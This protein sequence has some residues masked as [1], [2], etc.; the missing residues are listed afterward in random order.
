ML[1][2]TRKQY[3]AYEL[4]AHTN[5]TTLS[6]DDAI[7]LNETLLEM[8]T[9]QLLISGWSLE[10]HT[11]DELYTWMLELDSL[12][13]YFIEIVLPAREVQLQKE[14][15]ARMKA[16]TLKR[17][18]SV[19]DWINSLPLNKGREIKLASF[20]KMFRWDGEMKVSTPKNAED[21]VLT[22]SREADGSVRIMFNSFIGVKEEKDINYASCPKGFKSGQIAVIRPWI[23][24]K[25]MIDYIV[26]HVEIGAPY[27]M[28]S[29]YFSPWATLLYFSAHG[30]M[31]NWLIKGLS[32]TKDV[33]PAKLMLDYKTMQAHESIR[34]WFVSSAM[35]AGTP[36][37][38]AGGLSTA[39]S[40][41][42]KDGTLYSTQN[43]SKLAARF[44]SIEENNK[45]VSLGRKKI[46]VMLDVPEGLEDWFAPGAIWAPSME[47]MKYGVTRVTSKHLGVKGVTSPMMDLISMPAHHECYLA[48]KGCCKYGARG[49]Y[50]A[51]MTGNPIGRNLLNVSD[52]EVVSTLLGM[53]KRVSIKFQEDTYFV[54][55]VEVEEELSATNFY[56]IANFKYK[57][58]VIEDE[59]GEVTLNSSFYGDMMKEI[60]NNPEVNI[61]R[62][63]TELLKSKE[64]VQKPFGTACTLSELQDIYFSYGRE[65]MLS[66]LSHFDASLA[67]EFEL[68]FDPMNEDLCVFYTQ[69][70][71]EEIM[72]KSCAI[73]MGNISNTYLTPLNATRTKYHSIESTIDFILN[74]AELSNGTMFLGFKSPK[75]HVFTFGGEKFVIPSW[76]FMKTALRELSGIPGDWSQGCAFTGVASDYMTLAISWANSKTDWKKKALDH[77]M[78]VQF[79]VLHGRADKLRDTGKYMCML[80]GAHLPIDTVELARRGEGYKDPF[81]RV[82]TYAKQPVLFNKAVCEV[83]VVRRDMG[84]LAV[85]MVGSVFV[86]TGLMMRQGNDTD[87]DTARLTTSRGILPIYNG[88]DIGNKYW[89]SYVEG[90]YELNIL[91]S[92]LT[93]KKYSGLDVHSEIKKSYDLK[94]GIGGA[95]DSL[96]RISAMLEHYVSKGKMDFGRAR[97]MRELIALAA[98]NEVVRGIKH[99]S[100]AQYEESFSDLVS[101]HKLAKLMAPGVDKKKTTQAYGEMLSIMNDTSSILE[102]AYFDDA[103]QALGLKG[104]GDSMGRSILVMMRHT[105]ANDGLLHPI[106][107]E[108]FIGKKYFDIYHTARSGPDIKYITN[109]AGVSMV[110]LDTTFMSSTSFPVD[111]IN[112]RTMER[113]S[114]LSDHA[115]RYLRSRVAFG[116]D[117]SLNGLDTFYRRMFVTWN[118]TYRARVFSEYTVASMYLAMMYRKH[119]E[120]LPTRSIS[121]S[122]EY[123]KVVEVKVVGKKQEEDEGNDIPSVSEEILKYI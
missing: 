92:G 30:S 18:Q 78:S 80:P 76:K 23:L 33:Y 65:T 74:G 40:Y 16:E 13:E 29:E 52:E 27:Y 11:P 7:L 8:E 111:I 79:K 38:A 55:C 64:L 109:E 28:V 50:S 69:K 62:R 118:E 12:E 47:V 101:V 26:N 84:Y 70:E 106:G 95:T 86:N 117:T 116:E 22:F 103:E 5:L 49:L 67:K 113:L 99:T 122:E 63:I 37:Y 6:A 96:I 15:E 87:G 35:L 58:E 14:K 94:I 114:I 82:A 25:D 57:E 39:A 10:H 88:Q 4:D 107:C 34:R 72:R 91:D 59:D 45:G 24:N 93:V 32:L 75:H 17:F 41:Q 108:P 71:S 51:A 53:A 1:K 21:P 54:D 31:K 44:Q 102:E 3:L 97:I 89:D 43:V 115:K 110:N 104:N 112:K 119:L 66:Y 20:H 36:V 123:Q 73:M 85:A 61:T 46:L 83:K 81:K 90:E 100:N 121:V 19:L 48:S 120:L 42:E 2:M 68:M 56:T 9:K 98:Q 105:M 60:R 77:M